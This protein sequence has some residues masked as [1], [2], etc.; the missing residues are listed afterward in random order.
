[1]ESFIASGIAPHQCSWSSMW[2]DR[3]RGETDCCCY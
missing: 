2:F 3:L 1:M